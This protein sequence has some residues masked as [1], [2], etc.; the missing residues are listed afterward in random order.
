[1][2][3]SNRFHVVAVV[4]TFGTVAIILRVFLWVT[5]KRLLA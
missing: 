5:R 1:M 2:T 4:L 3:Q